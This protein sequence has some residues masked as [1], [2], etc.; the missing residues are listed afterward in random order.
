LFLLKLLETIKVYL[1]FH[2][3]KLWKDPRNSLLGQANLE[4]PLV[5]LEDREQEYDVER[6]LAVKLVRKKLKYK[7]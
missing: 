6:I 7:I 2:V 4:P 5:V 3:E 1:V